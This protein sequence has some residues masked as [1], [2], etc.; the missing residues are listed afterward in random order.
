MFTYS[1]LEVPQQKSTIIKVF[2]C[3][4]GGSNAV[5]RMIEAG[6]QG[7]DFVVINTDMQAL[8]S[9]SAKTKMGIGAKTT[10]G[11]G[12]GGDPKVGEDAALEDTDAIADIVRGAKMVFI[13]AG[14]GGGTGTGA[15]PVIAQIA[16]EEGALT[17]G[18]VTKPFDFEGVAKMS[19]AQNGIAKLA[20]NVDK[21]IVIPNQNLFKVID[22][23]TS[24]YD[25]FRVADDVLR[26]SVQGI[27][28]IITRN[29]MVNVD[30]RDVATTMR[31][32]GD[33]V[34][35]V[36]VGHGD[37]RASDAAMAAINNPML[38]DSRID[39][40][41]SILIN[42]TG[43]NNM[44][45]FEVEEIVK[46][47]KESADPEVLVLYGVAFDETMEDEI[48]VTVIA[49]NFN[50][51]E[52]RED[53]FAS[54][55]FEKT[56]VKSDYMHYGEYKTFTRPSILAGTGE[57]TTFADMPKDDPVNSPAFKTGIGGSS[58]LRTPAFYRGKIML[59]RE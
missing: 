10:G 30:F 46:T 51:R 52:S 22:K 7:V 50:C 4:G 48:S 53:S 32:S 37:T 45:M 14:M 47:I 36:G 29:G 34:M 44:T 43:S 21:L 2:G 31:G 16:K 18:V 38:E 41:K 17:I 59:D 28:D 42:I 1:M 9:S 5:D 56:G 58:D 13:T 19:L 35:G 33:A 25:A 54:V 40:A 23:R 8:N 55:G 3:G 26:Q 39:G 57:Q 49:T 11:L 20:D 15:A 6:V 27:S 12:A 24:V